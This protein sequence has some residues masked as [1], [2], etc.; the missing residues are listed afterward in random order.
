MDVLVTKPHINVPFEYAECDYNLTRKAHLNGYVRDQTYDNLSISDLILLSYINVI[1]SQYKYN[2]YICIISVR[3]TYKLVDKCEN[4]CE[5]FNKYLF[6]I[7]MVLMY[8]SV[9][10]IVGMNGTN[11]DNDWKRRHMW[12]SIRRRTRVCPISLYLKCVNKYSHMI[13]HRREMPFICTE[14]GCKKDSLIRMRWETREN[15]ILHV[16]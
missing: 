15:N 7:N 11:M 1:I 14:C 5:G 13:D 10:T 9:N 16:L 3:C 2:I 4:K 12:Y 8:I 6:L